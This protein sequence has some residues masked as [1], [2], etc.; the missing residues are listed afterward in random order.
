MH[1]SLP[2]VALGEAETFR[3]QRVKFLETVSSLFPAYTPLSLENFLE[4]SLF[5]DYS[6]AAEAQNIQCSHVSRGVTDVGFL[7]VD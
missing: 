7:T 5:P 6:L 3:S 1:Q 2:R 4:I